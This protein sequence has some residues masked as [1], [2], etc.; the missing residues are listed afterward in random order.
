MVQRCSGCWELKSGILSRNSKQSPPL[1]ARGVL[2]TQIRGP[3][4]SQSSP[5]CYLLQ[6]HNEDACH[7]SWVTDVGQV[8]EGGAMSSMEQQRRATCIGKQSKGLM[9]SVEHGSRE[10][11]LPERDGRATSSVER[12]GGATSSAE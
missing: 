12:E 1:N 5:E 2:G 8:L 7:A 6:G 10:T 11:P 4:M 3:K 9:S